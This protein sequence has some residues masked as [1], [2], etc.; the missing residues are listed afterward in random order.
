MFVLLLCANDAQALLIDQGNG[1]AYDTVNDISWP[2]DADILRVVSG[3]TRNT[4]A[5]NLVL[6][7]HGGFRLPTIDA[8][9]SLDDQ[10]PG[11]FGSNKGGGALGAVRRHP[12]Q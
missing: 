6:D 8:L 2:R 9:Y 3:A 4:N 5:N 11:A 7:G 10:L 1:L 12:V